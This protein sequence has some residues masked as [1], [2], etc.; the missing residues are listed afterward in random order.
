MAEIWGI[1]DGNT[2]MRGLTESAGEEA[3]GDFQKISWESLYCA[4]IF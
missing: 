2:G 3:A 1:A 4:D